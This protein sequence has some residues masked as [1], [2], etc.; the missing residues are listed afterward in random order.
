MMQGPTRYKRRF[1]LKGAWGRFRESGRTQ[2]HPILTRPNWWLR[3]GIAL[4]FAAL[5]IYLRWI[6]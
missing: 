3:Y 5:A 2:V 6:R 1:Q 4:S